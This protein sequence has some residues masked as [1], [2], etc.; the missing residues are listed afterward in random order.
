MDRALDHLDNAVGTLG[1]FWQESD[2][3]LHADRGIW[4]TRII[5][6]KEALSKIIQKKGAGSHD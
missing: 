3:L 4:T 2:V 1:E 6:A 5:A